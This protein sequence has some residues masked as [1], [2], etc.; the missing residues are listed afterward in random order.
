MQVWAALVTGQHDV[1]GNQTAALVESSRM[2]H[3]IHR[4]QPAMPVTSDPFYASSSVYEDWLQLVLAPVPLRRSLT[5]IEA[6]IPGPHVFPGFA[7]HPSRLT[8]AANTDQ[9][10][11]RGFASGPWLGPVAVRVWLFDNHMVVQHAMSEGLMS[12]GRT[13][14]RFAE[15]CSQWS[16]DNIFVHRHTTHM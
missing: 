16:H 3:G 8:A 11:P 2:L 9:W 4:I 14:G 7:R 13:E 10:Y 15:V 5:P 12:Q 6:Q 1:A